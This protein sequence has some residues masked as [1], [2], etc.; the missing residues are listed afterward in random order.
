MR[1]VVIIG[2]GLSGLAAAVE[3]QNLKIPY[4][5]IEVKK[6]LGGSIVSQTRDGFVLDGGG[7]AFLRNAD[8]S[9]L[10]DLGLQDAFVPVQNAHNH[11]L[12][13]FK[14]GT[15]M[16]IDALAN[17]L[18]GTIIKRMAVSS[19]GT[20]EKNFAICLENGLM[21]DAAALIVAAPARHVER[22][23][24]TLTPELS[25]QLFD[26]NYDTITRLSLGYR[27]DDL[28]M[29]PW[30]PWDM[31]VPFYSWT[32]D[33]HRAP[34][35]HILLHVGLRFPLEK[36]TPQALIHT[37]HEQIKARGEPVISRVDFWPEADP[38]PPH[39]AGYAEKM[40]ALESLL[41]ERIALAGSDYHG[42]SLAARIASG[43]KAAQKIAAA[44]K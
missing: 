13:A 16:L 10:D 17:D 14:N 11:D 38:L 24:R 35:D 39:T 1:D 40:T 33:P 41:P 25:L 19:L 18:R 22:M 43:R 3:L 12:V 34:E 36:T 27:K 9:F 28:P 21:L 4:R 30:F 6:R 8:W 2:G 31:A 37:V 15:Q 7:F 20:L 29:P 26:F 42:L 32:D 5:L 23:F 44:W